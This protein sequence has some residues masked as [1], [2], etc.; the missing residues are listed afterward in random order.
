M[1]ESHTITRTIVISVPWVTS[2]QDHVWVRGSTTAA[3]VG[4]LAPLLAILLG[5]LVPTARPKESII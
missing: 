3:T 5:E 2:A 4:E 1:S